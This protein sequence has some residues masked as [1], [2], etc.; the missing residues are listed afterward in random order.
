MLTIEFMHYIFSLLSIQMGIYDV[1]N[2]NLVNVES[3]FSVILDY[4]I[5]LIININ[6]K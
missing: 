4:R 6:Q 3:S 5:K 1:I 2:K